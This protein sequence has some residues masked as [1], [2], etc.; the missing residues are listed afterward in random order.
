MPTSTTNELRNN[1]IQL[2]EQHPVWH[3]FAFQM[4]WARF[5]QL[6]DGSNTCKCMWIMVQRLAFR[7]LFPCL[8]CG[9]LLSF[10]CLVH[11][12]SVFRNAPLVSE[13]LVIVNHALLAATLA[14]N[15]DCL[16]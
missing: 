6:S 13:G 16:Q 1:G 15:W 2:L 4:S 9:A 14:S 8:C 11:E 5:S 10:P 12:P 3:I 7:L